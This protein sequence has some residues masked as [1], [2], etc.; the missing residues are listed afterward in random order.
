M[1]NLGAWTFFCDISGRVRETVD[2]PIITTVA[3]MVPRDAVNPLRTRMRHRFPGTK[4][5]FK[6]GGLEGLS[7]VVK[8]MADHRLAAAV[9]Q[10]NIGEPAMWA[11]YFADGKEFIAAAAPEITRDPAFVHPAMTLRMQFLASAFAM[12]SGRLLQARHHDDGP[13]ATF[14]LE[15]VADTDFRD[16]DT[17][18]QFTSGVKEWDWRS[19][20]GASIGAYP[21]IRDARCMTEQAEPLLLLPDYLAGVYQHADRRTVLGAPVVA[22]EEASHAADDLRRRLGVGRLLFEHPEDFDDVYPLMHDGRGGV[23]LRRERSAT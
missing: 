7:K 17:E 3:V 4:T 23:V 21:I 8:I 1:K 10:V 15:V 12:L 2:N 9:Q 5:K 11:R 14:M 16:E 20:L 18:E 22:P 6:Y 19:R 13:P